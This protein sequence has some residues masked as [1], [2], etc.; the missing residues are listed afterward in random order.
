MIWWAKSIKTCGDL[1]YFEH[2][3]V[4]GCASISAFSLL[5]H[6]PEDIASFAVGLKVAELT[7]E[8]KKQ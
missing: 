7:E 5:V 3:A 2:S 1:N 4:S 6:F 8:I